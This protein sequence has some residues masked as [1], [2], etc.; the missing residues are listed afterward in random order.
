MSR[1]KVSFPADPLLKMLYVPEKGI[2][3][4]YYD[5][6]HA[7]L[8]REFVCVLKDGQE[9]RTPCGFVFDGG[10]IPRF[11]WDKVGGPF[12][13]Y[14]P[15]YII[16]DW[17]CAQAEQQREAGNECVYQD[18]REYADD[19]FLECLLALG[20]PRVKAHAMWVGVRAVA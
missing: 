5:G 17:L 12:E 4:K 3:R 14:V 7:M 2:P 16:H 13:F 6:R 15:A 18:L 20:C 8:L 9:V 10:S 11:L 19:L 1:K